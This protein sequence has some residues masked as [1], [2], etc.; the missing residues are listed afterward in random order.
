VYITVPTTLATSFPR[1]T[2]NVDLW[3]N[4]LWTWPSYANVRF[5]QRA[6]YV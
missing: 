5:N 1:V 3:P 2:V 6:K 4:D